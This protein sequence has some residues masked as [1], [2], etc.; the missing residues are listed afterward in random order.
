MNPA[1]YLLGRILGQGAYGHI[2]YATVRDTSEAVA[3]KF[4]SKQVL[5]RAKK[6]QS[7]ITEKECLTRF[8]SP[9][10]VQLKTSYEDKFQYHFVFEYLPNGT[11]TEFFKRKPSLSA[12]RHALAQVILILADVHRHSIIHRD[13]KPENFVFDTNFRLKI[14][15]FGSAK[16]FERDNGFSRGSFVGTIDYIAPEIVAKADQTPAIDLW[17]FGCL[18]YRAFCEQ[19]PFYAETRME[20][21][22]KIQKVNFEIPETVPE[23]AAD[24]IRRLLVLEAGDRLGAGDWDGDYRAVREHPFFEGVAWETVLTDAVEQ[25][26]PA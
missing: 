23:N 17:A 19:P 5:Q 21:Y 18:V 26:D 24:L 12:I 3:I 14:I 25:P 13:V 4:I 11:L 20:T 22:E 9:S 1:T 6:L 10:V 8:S 16:L 2:L 7:P 15:D